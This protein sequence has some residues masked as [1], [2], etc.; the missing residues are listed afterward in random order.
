MSKDLKPRTCLG[1]FARLF[2]TSWPLFVTHSRIVSFQGV[3]L[4]VFAF[5]DNLSAENYKLSAESGLPGLSFLECMGKY[6]ILTW[7][8]FLILYFWKPPDHVDQDCDMFS[9][10]NWIKFKNLFSRHFMYSF[11]FLRHSRAAS[12]FFR[13][14]ISRFLIFIVIEN[15]ILVWIFTIFIFIFILIFIYLT[16]LICCPHHQDCLAQMSPGKTW[17]R[18]QRMGWK[19]VIIIVINVKQLVS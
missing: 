4:I 18:G 10:T 9:K 16:G 15:L 8:Q 13:S 17:R 12:R 7:F 2:N 6:K 11:F 1:F 14:R 3:R 19:K 5:S